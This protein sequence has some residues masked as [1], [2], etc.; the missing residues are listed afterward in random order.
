[1]TEQSKY[2][3]IYKI[4]N[5]T[6][7]K[8]YIGKKCLNKGKKWINYWGSS[9]QLQEDIKIHGKANFTRDILRYCDNSYE[10]S[11]WEIDTQIKYNW[12]SS[13]CYNQNVSGKYFKSKLKQQD[14]SNTTNNI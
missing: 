5:L 14:G 1:M 3:I 4:T 6:N 2:G 10:L 8:Y 7:G 12:L 13:E 9:K 11:Y